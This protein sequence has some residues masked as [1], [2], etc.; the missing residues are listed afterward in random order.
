MDIKLC[1]KLSLLL[2]FIGKSDANSQTDRKN[3]LESERYNA[4]QEIELAGKLLEENMRSK[5]TSVSDLQMI[6]QRMKARI[7]LIEIIEDDINNVDKIIEDNNTD[8][9]NLKERRE[10][11]KAEY[12]EA[13]YKAYRNRGK[14]TFVIFI[15]ASNNLNQAYKRYRF[16]QI[17]NEYR[18]KKVD[19]IKEVEM[20]I[21]NETK[22]LLLSHDELI[23]L[24]ESRQNE[25]LLFEKEKR[26]KEQVIN[27]LKKRERELKEELKRKKEIARKIEKEIE[28]IINEERKKSEK[29]NIYM[30]L[31]PEERLISD[32]FGKN[33]GKLPWPVR[34]GIIVGKFGEQDHPSIKGI[35]VRNDGINIATI[36]NAEVR[37]VF[38]GTVT[39]VFSIPGSNYTVI[40]KHGNY[41]TLYHNLSN[42]YVSKGSIVDTKGAIGII[43][44]INVENEIILHFQIWKET[45][46]NNPEMW[47]SIKK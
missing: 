5:K 28:R 27:E 3:E 1:I 19:L 24:K 34:Q 13:V 37:S 15:L 10:R 46:R 16:V 7:K 12:A 21:E 6:N 20:K 42:V 14:V 39:K 35:K 36:N 31:T 30:S 40:I 18:R 45:E 26:S 29:G 44:G 38:K 2:F 47:L 43:S 33:R 9:S 41:Y 22:K 17:M 23:K 4:L 32:E 25:Y 11:L 8:I